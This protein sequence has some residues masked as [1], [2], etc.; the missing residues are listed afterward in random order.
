MWPVCLMN[1]TIR[2][3]WFKISSPRYGLQFDMMRIDIELWNLQR[4]CW[5]LS[6]WLTSIPN[7]IFLSLRNWT[8]DSE[9]ALA[10]P[11]WSIKALKRCHFPSVEWTIIIAVASK[12]FLNIGTLISKF[13]VWMAFEVVSMGSCISITFKWLDSG[14]EFNF[15]LIRFFR[16]MEKRVMTTSTFVTIEIADTLWFYAK[17]KF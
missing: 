2:L 10:S 7:W 14:I 17:T 16:R 11:P 6:K 13:V 8:T 15:D 4:N 12:V 1:F 9:I 5:V 3:D